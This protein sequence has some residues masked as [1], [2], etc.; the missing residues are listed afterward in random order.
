MRLQAL[1]RWAGVV[2]CSGVLVAGVSCVGAQNTETPSTAKPVEK[3]ATAKVPST[4][5]AVPTAKDAAATKKTAKKP[6]GRLPVFYADIVTEAQRQKIYQIQSG[7]A[8]KLASLA[9]QI[10]ETQAEQNAE[11]EAVLSEEQL[12]K[13]TAARAAAEAKRK[14]RAASIAA[15]AKQPVAK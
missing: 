9:A 6:A 7:Y 13:L 14:E 10:K 2:V 12:K 1:R 15:E 11:I 4:V 5:K 8:E 3:E